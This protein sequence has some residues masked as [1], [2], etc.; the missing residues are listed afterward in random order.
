MAITFSNPWD[1][2]EDAVRALVVSAT[3]IPS[4]RVIRGN[5]NGPRPRAEDGAF[6][7]VIVGD[8]I[9]IGAADAQQEVYNSGGAAGAEIAETSRGVR[10]LPVTIRVFTVSSVGSGSARALLA[11]VPTSLGLSSVRDALHTAG[12]TCFEPGTVGYVPAILDTK[13]EGRATLTMRFYTELTASTTTGYIT[14]VELTNTSVVP[15]SVTL[16]DAG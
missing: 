3:G 6:A 15:N 16:V 5:Q 10:E 9:P 4:I 13:W 2:L 8:A 14:A 12:L 11:Q 1:A 7:E